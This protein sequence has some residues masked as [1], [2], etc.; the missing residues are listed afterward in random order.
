MLLSLGRSCSTPNKSLSDNTELL[1]RLVSQCQQRSLECRPLHIKLGKERPPAHARWATIHEALCRQI[2]PSPFHTSRQAAN[3]R[4]V[5][6]LVHPISNVQGD[7][8]HSIEIIWT[9]SRKSRLYDVNPKLG[10]LLGYLQLLLAGQS[11]PWRLLP[12]PVKIGIACWS[13][14]RIVCCNLSLSLCS[15]EQDCSWAVI[16]ILS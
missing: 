12:I 5:S 16:G 7:I 3:G 8:P 15:G 10:Q 13:C 6:I 9:G 1:Y 4:D 14:L 2:M 11:C